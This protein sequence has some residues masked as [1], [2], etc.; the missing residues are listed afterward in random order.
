[1][2]FI[3]DSRTPYFPRPVEDLPR[4]LNPD[5]A[6]HTGP[7]SERVHTPFPQFHPY[8]LSTCYCCSECHSVRKPFVRLMESGKGRGR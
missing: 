3:H 6:C 5:C 1:V 4:C 8:E 7:E 2:K